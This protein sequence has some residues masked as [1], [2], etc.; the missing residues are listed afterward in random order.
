MTPEQHQRFFDIGWVVALVAI[1]LV[2][3]A[4]LTPPATG[5]PIAQGDI[6]YMG[7]TVDLSLAASWPDFA[8]AWCGYNTCKDPDVIIEL[9]ENGTLESYYIDP[10]LFKYGPWWRWDG[11]W[12]RGENAIAFVINPGVRPEPTIEIPEEEAEPEPVIIPE[13]PFSYFIASGDNPVLS[14]RLSRSDECHLWVFS[15]NAKTYNIPLELAYGMY[16]HQLTSAETASIPAGSYQGY[17]QC[18]GNNGWQDI[19]YENDVLDTPYDNRIVKDIVLSR[20]FSS[21]RVK[22]L[23]DELAAAIPRFD[24]KL[25][26]IGFTVTTPSATIIEVLQDEGSLY[27]SGETA[28]GDGTEIVIRI[29]PSSHVLASD[30]YAH[31]WVTTATGSVDKPR[32]FAIPIPLD[33]N[34]LTIGSHQII[35]SVEKNGYTSVS[36]YEFKVSDVYVMPEATKVPVRMI[37]GKDYEEIPVRITQTP[38]PKP[39]PTVKVATVATTEV[40][41]LNETVVVTAVPVTTTDV[42]VSR[43][44][45]PTI[46]VGV[47]VPVSAI[48]VGI[49]LRGRL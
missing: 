32:M 24:D 48:A 39:T 46:P 14:V 10:T 22:E 8:V 41:T 37:Y 7:E 17:I 25:Y 40:P 43:E 23:F 30:A 2:L 47:A 9:T 20:G 11:D 26:Q 44:T 1:C 18:N 5:T 6:I 29:D 3:L 13:G 4:F 19:Y 27:I 45:I 49:L 16:T 33:K 12:H 15:G 21:E 31:T 28:W 35:A 42:P 38:T 36:T 34:E